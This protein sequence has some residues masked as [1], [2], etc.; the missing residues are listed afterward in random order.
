MRFTKTKH[1]LFVLCA[2]CWGFTGVALADSLP[3]VWIPAAG[4]PITSWDS[5]VSGTGL[6]TV[7]FPTGFEFTLFGVSYDSAIV[8]SNGS[9]YFIP[10]GQPTP[11][12]PATPQPTASGNQF[13]QGLPR[14]APAW[15]NTQ[16]IDGTG[17]ILSEMLPGEAVFTF[18]NIASYIPLPGQSVAPS[19]LATFQV[20]LS[21]DN[22]PVHTNGSVTFAYDTFNS[23]NQA[24][25]GVA[26]SLVGSQLA[27]AGITSGLGAPNPGSVDLSGM[28]R[29]PNF[30]YSSTSSTIYQAIINNP[31][32][33]NS[34]LGGLDLFFTPVGLHWTVTSAYVGEPA[35]EPSTPIEITL[36]ALTL[37]IWRSRS[38]ARFRG[39]L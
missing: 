9:I 39:S 32:P 25:T 5:E 4:T 14:I 37:L 21:L 38:K 31:T 10:N 19:N 24:T 33:D 17:T 20:T 16:A 23:L 13:L 35:P 15:Y 7:Y 1:R 6:K 34:Q 29:S 30:S 26:N 18:E 36:S 11:P 12:L 22:N 3:P 8:S 2:G 27:I 28:A